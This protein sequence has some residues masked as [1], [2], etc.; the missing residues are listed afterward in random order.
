MVTRDATSHVIHFGATHVDSAQE[1]P[2]TSPS[3]RKQTI[4]GFVH[5]PGAAL[6]GGVAGHAGVFAQAEDVA[7]IF[8][9]LLNG[10]TY[11]GKKVLNKE[12]I[13][14]FTSYQTADSRRGFGFDKPSADK[15][16]G[17]PA[18]NHCSGYTFGHQGFTG[19]CGWADPATGVVFVLLSNRVYPTAD[20]NNINR[21][22]I[23]T[24][25]QDKI[26]EALNIP[27][28]KSRRELHRQQT[29]K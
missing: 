29:K 10:G 11:K 21:Y 23:R 3:F 28:N 13:S 18:S 8:Q 20:N 2:R 24:T 9:M 27:V 15:N 1:H 4:Q 14:L 17:G 16:D 26:Y 19:T 5:D 22:S 6:F 7:V 25:A 12:T